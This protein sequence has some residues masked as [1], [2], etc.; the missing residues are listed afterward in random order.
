MKR[1]ILFASFLLLLFAGVVYAQVVL[2]HPLGAGELLDAI[3]FEDGSALTVVQYA[4]NL[5]VTHYDIDGNKLDETVVPLGGIPDRL[6]VHICGR[7]VQFFVGYQ[8]E[9]SDRFLWSLQDVQPCTAR[10][11]IPLVVSNGGR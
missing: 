3:G 10:V 6:I 4:D 7:Y 1:I 9:S 2:T 11:F 8:E 5:I